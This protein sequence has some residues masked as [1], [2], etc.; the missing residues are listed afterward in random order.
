[1]GHLGHLDSSQ[2]QAQLERTVQARTGRRVRQLAIEIGPGRIVLKGRASTYHVKQ[3]AQHGV[4]DLLPHIHLENS[5]AV[6]S[7]G[8]GQAVPAL[9]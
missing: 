7:K 4:R 9:N 5:I 1:M 6:D 3:L 2:L 8:E